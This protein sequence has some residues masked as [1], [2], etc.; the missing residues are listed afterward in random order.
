MLR[1][2]GEINIVLIFKWYVGQLLI[3]CH[4]I[5][6]FRIERQHIEVGLHDG[7]EIAT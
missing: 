3:N 5:Y 2:L 4:N 1:K 7:G 6:L